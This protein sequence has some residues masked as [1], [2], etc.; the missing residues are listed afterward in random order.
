M[1]DISFVEARVRALGESVDM[2]DCKLGRNIIMNERENLQD[3][4]F[5]LQCQEMQKT[6]VLQTA[7]G[8]S[9]CQA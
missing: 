7:N 8:V 9:Q 1:N 2:C 3:K 6:Q 4:L 5:N